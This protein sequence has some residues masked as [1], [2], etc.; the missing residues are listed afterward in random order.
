M[1]YEIDPFCDNRWTAYLDTAP[2]G[3]SVFHSVGWLRALHTTYSYRVGVLTTAPPDA[4]TISNGL[5]FCDVS[6]PWTGRRTVSLP[7]SDYCQPLGDH[8]GALLAALQTRP[9]RYAEVRP[10]TPARSEQ[11]LPPG[12]GVAS[13]YWRHTLDLRPG[14]MAVLSR[15]HR[16]SIQR[17]IRRAEREGLVL[18]SGTVGEFFPLFV[19]TRRRHGAPPP[20]RQWFAN[21]MA[22][23]PG[24]EIHIA[25]HRG[26]PVAS[27]L[28]LRHGST[29][30]YKYGGSDHRQHP[31]GAIPALFW[32]V[33][34][35]ACAQGLETLD[36]GRSDRD[37]DGL[38][39]F[40]ERLGAVREELQYWRSPA[41]EVSG[42]P[43][44]NNWLRNV[45]PWLPDAAFR[46]AGR[47][48]YPH[49]G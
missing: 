41:G 15:M 22:S 39:Q 14:A 32:K 4:P 31:L 34:Q 1:T 36:L 24:S 12:Y 5:P 9:G 47:L 23:A 8:T 26:H 28:T 48:L 49:L 45:W 25:E 3:G 33:V 20:S 21:L 37:G 42:P 10:S 40:K 29:L 6:S 46:F 7:F 44:A 18:R 16:D 17:K 35:E 2:H 11:A 27:L 19:L 13:R 43:G 38:I 30:Y